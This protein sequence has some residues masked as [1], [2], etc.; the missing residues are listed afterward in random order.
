MT[1]KWQALHGKSEGL[2][3][4]LLSLRPSHL[5]RTLNPNHSQS[6]RSRFVMP[7]TAWMSVILRVM[8]SEWV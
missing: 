7:F 4:K 2:T 3:Y 8:R 1:P 6:F 5:T